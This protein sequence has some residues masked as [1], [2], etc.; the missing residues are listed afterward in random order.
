MSDLTIQASFNSGEWAPNLRARVDLVKYRAGAALLRNFFVDYRGGATTRPGSR[1]ILQ[2]F[3]STTTRLIPFQASFSV[4]YVLEF[5]AG[6][7][8]FYNNGRPVLET[9]T[10]I[11]VATAGPPEV[12][13]DTAH[14]YSNGDWI[15]AG[16][17]YYIVA[18]VL[19]N[20]YT[21]TDLAGNAINTNPFTLPAAAQRIYTLASPYAATELAQIKYSQSVSQMILCHPN[22]PPYLLTL[23][24]ATNWT[25]AA[26]T[27]GATVSA[28]VGQAVASTFAGGTINYAYVVTAVDSNGQESD[29]SAY[30]T[31]ALA[32]DLRTV[33][34]T[35]TISWSAVTGAVSYNV[36]RAEIRYGSAVPAGAQFGFCGITTS[37]T[38]IDSNIAPDTASTPPVSQ[39]PFSGTGVASVNVTAGGLVNNI[40][41]PSVS[42][43]GGGGS[44]AAGIVTAHLNGAT[45]ANGGFGYGYGDVLTMEGG[46]ILLV[47][48]IAGGG[49]ITSLFIANPGALTTGSNNTFTPSPVISTP[50]GGKNASINL[51]WVVASVGLTSPGV[52]YATPPAVGFSAGGAAATAVLGA[53]S[54]GN[55]TVPGFFQQRLVL[56]G[57]V[58]S[59]Q[60]FNMSKTGAYFNFD[61]SQIT[62]ADDAIQGTLVSGQLNTIQAMIPQPAGL[63][64]LTDKQS[65]LINGGTGAGSPV[66]AIQIGANAQSFNGSAG[67]QPIVATNNIIFL[68]AK[69][70]VVRDM[71]FSIYTSVYSG[72]DISALSSH[73]FY[74]F[75][76]LE[77]AWAEEPYKV[78]WAVRNDGALLSLTYLKEQEF[79]AW[80]HSDTNGAYKSIATITEA[81][82]SGTGYIDAIYTIV[83]R[84]INGATVQYVERQAE[85]NLGAGLSAAWQVDA[86]LAYT[87]VATLNFTGAQHLANT[88]VVGIATDN[89]TSPRTVAIDP[90]T[91]AADGSF[92]LPAPT[93]A[94]A[95]GYTYALVG[96]AF[97]PQLQTLP[98]ET[99]DP[100]IQGKLKSI[101]NVDVRVANTL[102]LSI[103]SDFSH[104]VP[105]KDLII[106][107]VS[108]ML[109]GQSSQIVTDLVN[110]DA[111]TYLDPTY[112]TP[113]QYC[114]QQSLPYPAT[115]LGVIPDLVVGDTGGG[116]K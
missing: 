5:G 32:S 96:L 116:R 104:L 33:A 3:K 65:W 36:Y 91:V 1:Y 54:S 69:G 16:N 107:N 34:G 4:S 71:A 89:G 114:I 66:S 115:V 56:A 61:T 75:T 109:A 108:S 87:G 13:T 15:F 47:N 79:V 76:V 24:T 26:I 53:P 68:Q 10:S 14:G 72:V 93:N 62:Q 92:S 22:H 90:L 103:G 82:T 85:L 25:L 43:S 19:T 39:N 57:P 50:S 112:T 46:A 27:F 7:V 9:A 98:I 106:G 111:R 58:S 78:L 97:L 88:S 38:F 113:G 8:R 55:P 81:S 83:A 84:S 60:Q 94:G 99:G 67:P 11:T 86:G 35:N 74:G 42:F 44:G 70:S 41:V 64:I 59:P 29:P 52:G 80:A 21:L 100:T 12:F 110:G 95:T 40:P 20:S 28:P 17:A 51:S 63:I 102:G 37:T 49:V 105:M 23:V 18:N 6:Y 101:K 2:T 30:A 45:V 31:A 77:W 48:G 73:L